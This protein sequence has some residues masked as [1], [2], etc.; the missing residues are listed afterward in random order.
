MNA[1]EQL[2]QSMDS[3]SLWYFMRESGIGDV[4]THALRGC[5]QDIRE[6]YFNSA[7]MP[8]RVIVVGEFLA[9][10]AIKAKEI[11]DAQQKLADIKPG[12][13]KEEDAQQKLADIVYAQIKEVVDAQ[14]EFIN[15]EKKFRKPDVTM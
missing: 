9:G 2:I 15:L 14:Q 8:Y 12:Q 4:A 5:S 1:L 11:A 3:D 13:T 7:A 6:K 10:S